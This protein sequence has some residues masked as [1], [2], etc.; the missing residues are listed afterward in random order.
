MNSQDTLLPAAIDVEHLVTRAG[1][2]VAAR[3]RA[4]YQQS[5]RFRVEH[6]DEDEAVVRV[7]GSEP[8]RVE[9]SLDPRGAV[10][11]L[12]DCPYADEEPAIVCKHKVAAALYLKNHTRHSAAEASW[13]SVLTK[14]V[15]SSARP[16]QDDEAELLFFSL[17]Q[18]G[19]SWAVVPYRVAAG[20]FPETSSWTDAAAI[21]RVVSERQLSSQAERIEPYAV[22]GNARRYP[23]ATRA[24]SSLVKMLASSGIY[25]GNYY[26]SASTL[27]F[28]ALFAVLEGGPLYTGTDKNPLKQKLTVVPDA[29]RIEMEMETSAGGIALRAVGVAREQVFSLRARETKVISPHP[30]WVLS[31]EHVFHLDESREL[32]TTF[33][34][35]S[36]LKVPAAAE[37]VFLEKHLTPLAERFPLRGEEVRW[38]DLE[39]AAC[40]PRLYLSEAGAELQ[41]GLKYAYGDYEVPS[42]RTVPPQ[43]IRR[44]AETGA[45]VRIRRQPERESAISDALGT[46]A[47][48]LKR[49][50]TVGQF[51]LRSKVH[52]FDFLLRHVPQLTAAGYEIYGEEALTLARVNRHRPTISFGV[53]SGIDWFDV[54][55]TVNSASLKF[56]SRRFAALCAGA[57]AL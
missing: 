47:H 14:V 35:S 19:A 2:S 27:D 7:Q 16:A 10:M 30:L 5:W 26:G 39:D 31:G 22:N 57:S 21:E 46:A 41:V 51:A 49:T 12:C 17:Q 48:A 13:E 11:A 4:Y 24:Q 34:E 1:S 15:R 40:V 8:Y 53:T 55:A 56:R 36:E 28:N 33:Q 42:E 6:L 20:F 9:F 44:N 43:S 38:E 29:A 18:R 23:N 54:R 52:P 32:F 3:G 50:A 25:Y 37:T 45:L